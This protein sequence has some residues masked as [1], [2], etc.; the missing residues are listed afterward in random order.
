MSVSMCAS[1]TASP[2]KAWA[3]PKAAGAKRSSPVPRASSSTSP[4]PADAL[5]EPATAAPGPAGVQLPGLTIPLVVEHA[6]P[7]QQASKPEGGAAARWSCSPAVPAAGS[8]SSASGPP[9]W[10]R[11]IASTGAAPLS[12]AECPSSSAC[13]AVSHAS[14]QTSCDS[15]GSLAACT[16]SSANPAASPAGWQTT[17]GRAALLRSCKPCCSCAFWAGSRGTVAALD[18]WLG[19]RLPRALHDSGVAVCGRARHTVSRSCSPPPVRH[20]PLPAQRRGSDTQLLGRAWRAEPVA[21]GCWCRVTSPGPTRA[22][23]EM[24][25]RRATVAVTAPPPL[26]AGRTDFAFR[27]MW[28]VGCTA[29]SIKWSD[30]PNSGPRGGSEALG[31]GC[32]N[33]PGGAEEAPPRPRRCP[34]HGRSSPAA[35][36][37]PL[38]AATASATSPARPATAVAVPTAARRAAPR[39]AGVVDGRVAAP[40]SGRTM[41]SGA[42]CDSFRPGKPPAVSFGPGGTACGE[43]P[44]T[45]RWRGRHEMGNSRPAGGAA[46][47]AAASAR[48]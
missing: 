3:A 11:S 19:G 18:G 4:A 31:V 36:A 2:E 16:S 14:W 27:E 20:V 34:L 13:P 24:D 39:T 15:A 12:L 47:A 32:G 40:V 35:C 10:L 23:S 17:S 7:A 28:L 46:V 45:G 21:S 38:T 22:S 25:N 9:Q 29:K 42:K 1:A 48:A 44:L 37:A 33:A 43:Y 5:P 6:A 30:E 41:Q 8:P 26:V